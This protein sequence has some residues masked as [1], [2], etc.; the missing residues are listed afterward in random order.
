MK[1]LGDWMKEAGFST[2]ASQGTKEAYIKHLIR[3]SQGTFIA[4][5]SEKNEIA[6]SAPRVRALKPEQLSFDFSSDPSFES[7]NAKDFAPQKNKKTS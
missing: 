2:K 4:T 1:K 6:K 3:V 7:A 5:P